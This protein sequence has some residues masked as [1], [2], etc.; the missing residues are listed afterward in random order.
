MKGPIARATIR[1][2]LVLGLRL[3]VQAGTLLLIARLLGPKYYGAFAGVTSLAV[4]LGTLSTFGMHLVLLAE[5]SREAVRHEVILPYV[6]PTTCLF[7]SI[8]LALYLLICTFALSETHVPITVLIMI[9]ATETLLQPL[10]WLPAMD[11]Q[12]HGRIA[13]S[14]LLLTLPLGLRLAAAGALLLL[15]PAQPLVVYSYGYF[16]ASLIALAI[17]KASVPAWPS[18]RRWRLP[19]SAEL[20][21]T[22]GYAALAITATTPAELDK[23]LATR[24]LPLV[25][26]GQYA[27]GSRVVGAAILPVIAMMLSVLPRLFREGHNEVKRTVHL[28]RWIFGAALSYSIALGAAL[29]F[30]APLFAWVFGSGYQGI[31]PIMRWLCLAVPGMALR[32]A[33][34]SVLMALG[35]PWMRVCFEIAGLVVLVVSAVILTAHFSSLGMPLALV[36]S[37]WTMA[38]L[39]C[40]LTYATCSMRSNDVIGITQP[41]NRPSE[42]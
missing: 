1:T 23:T 20:R 26:S 11:H 36:C 16:L 32:I 40:L 7:G 29:W 34:G 21:E 37:E 18:A 28:L 17:A 14:Q 33:A 42:T 8:L 24:L 39:G 15:H 12:A 3:I 25:A 22:A 31:E 10:S 38:M 5:T 19:K 35:K 30:S 41:S 4:M 2:T 6:V 27:A 13:R 9:G